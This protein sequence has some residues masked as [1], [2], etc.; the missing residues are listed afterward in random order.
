MKMAVKAKNLELVAKSFCG[1]LILL[2]TYVYLL[3]LD[4]QNMP[5]SQNITLMALYIIFAISCLN[6]HKSVARGLLFNGITWSFW[7]VFLC[8]APIVQIKMNR[9][10]LS[11]DTTPE[12][13]HSG[14]LIILVA[15]IFLWLGNISSNRPKDFVAQIKDNS[16]KSNI[17]QCKE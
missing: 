14:V 16:R 5:I 7:L 12:N 1:L 15:S 6:L 2:L 13:N 3:R 4:N 8:I 9:F 11:V 10:P 17:S